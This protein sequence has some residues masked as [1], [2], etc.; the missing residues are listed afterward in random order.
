VKGEH[1]AGK[2]HALPGRQ[3]GG[4]RAQGHR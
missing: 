1:D 2:E 4:G 3:E